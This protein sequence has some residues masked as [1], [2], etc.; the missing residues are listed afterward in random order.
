VL[1]YLAVAHFGRGRGDF[2][3]GEYPPH[4][5]PLVEQAVAPHRARL[6][7]AWSV[8][9]RADDRTTL[10]SR[11]RALCEAIVTEVLAQ[12]YPGSVQG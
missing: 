2:V 5:G 7:D 4:W 10:E 1:R 12:L 6:N 3:E 8:A 9:Q 11:L